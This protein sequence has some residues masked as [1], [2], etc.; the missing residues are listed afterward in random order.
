MYA[1]GRQDVVGEEISKGQNPRTETWRH[2]TSVESVVAVGAPASS[3][4]PVTLRHCEQCPD[5]L[6]EAGL[7]CCDQ[8]RTVCHTRPLS[9]ARLALC[10]SYSKK[11]CGSGCPS[12]VERGTV[13][14][15]GGRP[16]R[17]ALDPPQRGCSVEVVQD[18]TANAVGGL[19]SLGP[20]PAKDTPLQEMVKE[21]NRAS[22]K[23]EYMRQS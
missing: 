1:P 10:S 5:E 12:S 14:D 15:V 20:F 17:A 21:I 8:S 18:R 11:P 9:G 22:R 16:A 19:D 3:V 23:K 6:R 7:K 4:D 2:A 13:A